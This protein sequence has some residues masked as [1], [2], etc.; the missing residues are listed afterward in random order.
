MVWARAVQQATSLSW[1]HAAVPRHVH[2]LDGLANLRSY[3]YDTTL[4]VQCMAKYMIDCKST[5]VAR[6]IVVQPS[7][8]H[9]TCT[10]TC[11]N[12]C[13]LTERNWLICK[14]THC[15]LHC[16]TAVSS[17]HQA[18]DGFPSVPAPGARRMV[19]CG[20]LHSPARRTVCTIPTFCTQ[21]PPQ[22]LE[23]VLP[24]I[25]TTVLELWHI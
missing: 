16:C 18:L 20:C 7:P 17:Q 6:C 14:V 24:F 10:T 13:H 5:T 3:E 1:N 11:K 15:Q 8:A 19:S 12:L 4:H 25:A 22:N 2:C 23:T 9:I 21:A